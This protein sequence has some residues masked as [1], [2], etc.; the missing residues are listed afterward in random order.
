VEKLAPLMFDC[1]VPH[2]HPDAHVRGKRT[3]N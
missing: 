2:G 1:N 3:A